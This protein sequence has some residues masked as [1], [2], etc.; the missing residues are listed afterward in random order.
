MSEITKT[1]DLIYIPSE[2][3]LYKSDGC[4]PPCVSAHKKVQQ[5]I[6]VLVTEVKSSTYEIY[7]ED[8][9]WLVDKENTYDQN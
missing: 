1:G 6:S 3:V 5:P 9:Y 8:E 4:S 2:V 7:F